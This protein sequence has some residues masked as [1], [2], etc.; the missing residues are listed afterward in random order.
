MKLEHFLPAVVWWGERKEITV[1][2]FDM[3]KLYMV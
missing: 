1:D 3:A 2:G